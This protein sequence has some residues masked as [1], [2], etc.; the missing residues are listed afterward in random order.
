MEQIF[1]FMSLKIKI[2]IRFFGYFPLRFGPVKWNSLFYL[3][4]ILI[5]RVSNSGKWN[6]MSI[7]NL[8]NLNKKSFFFSEFS[9]SSRTKWF[10]TKR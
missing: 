7:E 8:V 3:F 1:K 2:K 9:E 5:E 6:G 4:S 10:R